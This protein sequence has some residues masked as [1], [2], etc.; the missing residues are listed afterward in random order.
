[1][2][3]NLQPSTP[4]YLSHATPRHSLSNH[5]LIQVRAVW[6]R[7]LQRGAAEGRSHGSQ[8]ADLRWG[9]RRQASKARLF[10]SLVCAPTVS[11]FVG[12]FSK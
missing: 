11:D 2:C 1:M 9:L 10:C 5:L 8:M 7:D 12:T 6:I 3:A 4:S